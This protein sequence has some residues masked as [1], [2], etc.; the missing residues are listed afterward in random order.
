MISRYSLYTTAD[1]RDRF[2]LDS[3]LPKGIKPRYNIHPTFQAPV[4]VDRDNHPTV[5]R[6]G[7]GLVPKGA[8]DT[9]S[10]FRYKTYNVPS[11]KILGKHSWETA[12]RHSRCLV[13]ANGF[14][15]LVGQGSEKQ[16]Y[17]MQLKESPLFAFAG[18]Y[19][20]WENAGVTHSTYSIVTSDAPHALRQ[21]GD[22]MPIILSQSEEARWL[23]TSVTDASALFDMLA[24]ALFDMLRPISSEQLTVTEVS[25]D[26]HSLKIDTVKLITPL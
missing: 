10:V 19:S 16:A 3:G 9:N 12:V 6:M 5:E 13:P 25:P 20:S 23:D 8:K 7:W 22:R 14:Y 26:I 21:L 2:S 24:S 18:I 11:E 4:I 15:Q 17:Y 1:L